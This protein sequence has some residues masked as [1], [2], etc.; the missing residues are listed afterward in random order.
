MT[1]PEP[2]P[3]PAL[4]TEA[5]LPLTEPETEPEPE[6]VVVD[7]PPPVWAAPE[8]EPVSITPPAAPVPEPAPVDESPWRQPD[9]AGRFGRIGTTMIDRGLITNEQLDA[10][11]ELQRTTGRRVGEI[12]VEMGAISR[13]ELARVLADHMGVPFVDLRAKP[14]DP[15]LASAAPGRGRPAL[16]RTRDRPLERPARHRD[17]QSR[18]ISSRSTI[19]RWSCASPSSPRWRSRR[20]SSPRSTASTACRMSRRRSTRRRATTCRST[21]EAAMRRASRSTRARSSGSST[22]C[23]TRRSAT[24]RPTCT[25]SPPRRAIAI[26]YRVD[27]VL[28]DSSE[29]PLALLRPLVSRVK[30]LANLD[31]AQNRI[32]QDG[33][34]SVVVQGRPVDVRVV[35]VPTAAGE[36][37]ILRLLDP[38]RDTLDMSSLGLTAAEEARFVPP[39]FASQGAAFITGPDRFGQD[40]DGVHV[41]VGDQHPLEEHHLGRRSGRVPARRHQADPDQPARRADVRRRHSR[42]SCAPT[43]TSCSSVRCAT[44][45]P[46]ASRPTRRSPATSCCRRSHAT[47]AAAAPMRLDRDGR[48]AVS[49]RVG[50]HARRGAAPRA[51][52]VRPVRRAGRPRRA[53]TACASSAPTDE[54]LDGATDPPRGRLPGVPEHRLRGPL[55]DLRDHAGHRTASAGSSSTARR[56]PEIER[57]AVEEGMETMRTAALRRVAAGLLSIEEMMRI[58]S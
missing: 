7:A 54:I 1:E 14:P 25:S 27:G 56:V 43:P 37:V 28:H 41:A 5:P 34:F 12:L 17:G 39:F 40:V 19:C 6:P 16:P 52:V 9:R 24:T 47:R 46:R 13:F 48:R 51:Q 44:P 10:A 21:D 53:S 58:V 33:R 20:T 35:T 23:W 29:V 32:A 15:I 49:R 4:A 2:E 22:R 30:I 11:L 57:L 3:E 55:A 50:A 8:P 26:R 31:I 42:R 45:R 36:S 18:P 38:T